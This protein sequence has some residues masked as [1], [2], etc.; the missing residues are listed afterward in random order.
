MIQVINKN[1]PKIEH[2]CPVC[3]STIEPDSDIITCPN[4]QMVY[5]KECWEDNNG[6]ATYGCPSAGCLAPPPMKIELSDCSLP[7]YAAPGGFSRPRLCPFCKTPMERGASFCWAC[8]RDI[9]GKGKNSSGIV[10]GVIISLVLIL[11]F[12]VIVSI[13][14]HAE[15]F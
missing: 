5:H 6:C 1:E 15:E 13:A 11:L 8:G 9:S 10:L 3:F 12:L 2:Q 14:I 4:C 7:N